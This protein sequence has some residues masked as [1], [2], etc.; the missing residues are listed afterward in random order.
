[1]VL[2]IKSLEFLDNPAYHNTIVLISN[3][4]F[5]YLSMDL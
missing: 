4:Y 2:K 1:M 3:I 5:Y